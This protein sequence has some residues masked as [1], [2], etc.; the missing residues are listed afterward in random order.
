MERGMTKQEAV[1]LMRQGKRVRHTATEPGEYYLIVKVEGKEVV[2]FSG[3]GY[4][5]SIGTID[6]FTLLLYGWEEYCQYKTLNE[7]LSALAMIGFQVTIF[8]VVYTDRKIRLAVHPPVGH[9][10]MVSEAHI[11]LGLYKA[12]CYEPI[13]NDNPIEEI[14]SALARIS[15][16][17]EPNGE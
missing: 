7:V 13:R 6:S 16:E 14:L 8:P 2:M 17:E 9:P 15:K 12:L 5:H 1:E 4:P 10:I 3:H 11:A